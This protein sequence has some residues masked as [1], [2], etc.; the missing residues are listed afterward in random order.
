MKRPNK[1]KIPRLHKSGWAYDVVFAN[2]FDKPEGKW[3]YL[4]CPDRD[5]HPA[6]AEELNEWLTRAIIWSKQKS[7]KKLL[8]NPERE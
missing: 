2:T 5:L 6:E 3:I 4:D 7:R 8:P 1:L